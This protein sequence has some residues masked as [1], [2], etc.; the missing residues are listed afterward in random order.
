MIADWID[1]ACRGEGCTPEQARILVDEPLDALKDGATRIRETFFG[2]TIDLCVIVNARSGSC[3]E[4]CRFCAQSAHHKTGTETYALR[5]PDAILEEAR[6]FAGSGARTYGIVTSGPTVKE[7]EL[8]S[9]REAVERIPE[10]T[11]LLPCA[12]LGALTRAQLRVLKEAGLTR[13]H[14]NLETSEAFYPRI[15]TTHTWAERVETVRAAQEVGLEVCCGGLFGLGE[16]WED[17]IDLAC[18]LRSLG[19]R[20]VPVNFLNPVPGTPLEGAA[21]IPAEEGLR[22]LALYRFM[23]PRATIRVCGGRPVVL[24]ERQEEMFA[25]GANALMTGDY[26]TT[27]GISPETD[28]ARIRRLGLRV[29]GAS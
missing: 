21:P 12:S 25:A 19:I 2:N 29:L 20:S 17:R 15:C 27:A 13:F 11:P 24:G 16:S 28:C 23:L 18:T 26:L 22:I 4:D 1:A 9:I 3:R 5:E 8:A 6:R 10:E 14:H 7:A